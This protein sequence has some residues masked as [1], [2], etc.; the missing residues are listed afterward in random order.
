MEYNSDMNDRLRIETLAVHAGERRP[1]PEGSVVFPIFQGTVF[2][3]PPGTPYGDIPYNRL[4]SAPAHRYLHDKLKALEGAEAAVATA[5]GMAAVTTCLL[6]LLKKGDHLLLGDCLYGGTHSFVTKFADDLG[7]SY[8]FV[9][10][11]RP[12]TWAAALT[13]RTRVFLVESITN[14]L[15]RVG[16]L[17]EIAMFAKKSNVLSIIDNTFA[18]PINFRPLSIGFDLVFHS[19]TKY[20]NGHS[21]VVAGCVMGSDALIATV[22]RALAHYGAALD[23]HAGYLLARGIK[24]MALRVK[25]QNQCAQ[26][27]ATFLEGH[28]AVA[29]VSYPGLEKHPDHG[30]AKELFSGFGGMLSIELKGGVHAADRM[31]SALELPAVA[32]SLG[33]V[34][35]LVTRPSTTSHSGMSAEDRAKLGISDDLVRISCGIENPL[36]LIDDFRQAL[37]KPG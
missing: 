29:K 22:R 30:Y 7:W 35:S 11:H 9:D 20:L 6:S 24:T 21:D 31:M 26:E 2:E 13:A 32:P 34:E 18:S 28:P 1:G 36:D 3:V 8:T 19:A 5:S 15:I 10:P 12:E 23:P 4:S 17:R 27:L 16:R 37:A 33:G 14:P 25:A